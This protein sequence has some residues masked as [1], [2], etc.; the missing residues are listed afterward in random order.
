[1]ARSSSD[2][3][4]AVR[5]AGKRE[6]VRARWVILRAR[7]V[8]LRAR[9]V[10][11]RA[12]WVTL[13]CKSSLGILRARWVI[14]RARWV[15]LRARWVTQCTAERAEA[16]AAPVDVEAALAG[17]AA[18]EG[19]EEDL[20]R[21]LRRHHQ[22]RTPAQYSRWQVAVLCLSIRRCNLRRS[23]AALRQ[24]T[25]AEGAAGHASSTPSWARLCLWNVECGVVGS[26][27]WE[28]GLIGRLPR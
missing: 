11:L 2:C 27:G 22:V 28:G 12:R 23:G 26:E 3:A 19:V 15:I 18:A 6:P 16:R 5:A 4:A 13:H 17:A 14:L 7:W 9:W 10:I 20:H 25:A 1:V 24:L 21:D 8:T